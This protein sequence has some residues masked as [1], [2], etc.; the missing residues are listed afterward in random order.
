MIIVHVVR[1]PL[2][3]PTVAQ[4]VLT[5]HVGGLNIQACRIPVEAA[6]AEAMERSNTPNSG[7]MKA[8]APPIGTFIRSNPSGPMDTS[9]GRWPTNLILEHHECACTGSVPAKDGVN[10][11]FQWE[12]QEGCPIQC[13]AR[14]SDALN[15]HPA[16]NQGPSLMSNR[17]TRVFMGGW[18]PV[19]KN[20]DTFQDGGGAERFF[21]QVKFR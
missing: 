10:K 13:L 14:Q 9:V 21:K 20:P 18:N 19:Y 12:C 6:D 8:A 17:K 16:G 3:K 11:V 7:R 2:A 5:H 4:N 1:K 15:I